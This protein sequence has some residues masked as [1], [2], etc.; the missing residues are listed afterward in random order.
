[1]DRDSGKE[2]IVFFIS[3]PVFRDHDGDSLSPYGGRHPKG[4]IPL[5]PVLL[6]HGF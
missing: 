1:M 4:S 3:L 5:I 6:S 2:P